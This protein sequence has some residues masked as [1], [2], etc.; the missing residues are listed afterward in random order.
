MFTGIVEEIGIVRK[1][2]PGLLEIAADVVLSD[3]RLGDSVAVD[4]TCL[5]VVERSERTFAVNVEPETLRRTTLG[6]LAVGRRVNLERALAANGRLGGHIVQ[7][8]IDGTGRIS[9]LRPDGTGLIARFEASRELMR[10]IVT[11]GFIAVN[12]ISLT[13]VEVG[14]GWFTVALVPYTREHVALLDGGTG[15]RVNLE[16]D[17][18]AKYVE[19]LLF[20]NAHDGQAAPAEGTL[21]LDKLRLAG[22]S[23]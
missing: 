18:L 22:F 21:T 14:D 6:D 9:E 12:G 19:R 11:K 5:T 3:L 7:G 1:A 4:G 15:A 13:V 2:R 8:H 17:V 20:A 10:Y 16:V 23:G